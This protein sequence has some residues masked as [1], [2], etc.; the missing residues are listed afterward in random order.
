MADL[1]SPKKLIAE[2]TLTNEL[3]WDNRINQYLIDDWLSNFQ[4]DVFDDVEYEK[5]LALWLLT[6]FVFYNESEVNH[7]CK[8]VYTDFI[9]KQLENTTAQDVDVALNQIHAQTMFTGI[10]EVGESGAMV[11]YLFRTV[12]NIGIHDIQPSARVDFDRIVF[13]DDVTLSINQYSQVWKYLKDQIKVY[14]DKDI[15]LITLVASED[16]IEFL[17]SKGVSVTNAITLNEHSR[18][19]YKK[20]YVF[21]LNSDHRSNAK[22]LC[23]HYGKKCLPSDPLG[24]S[25]SQYLFGFYYNIPDNTLPI[26]WSSQ[27]N[28]KPIFRRYHKNYQGTNSNEL[29]HFV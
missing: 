2:I 24:Y 25:N 6:N 10:G 22:K 29:G 28:W 17:G 3:V 12:N 7:L 13:V 20:S 21:Q 11:M 9:H 5:S 1:P 16:A 23:K 26:I 18:A 14:N 27:N 19:F 15:H 4:G 8:T